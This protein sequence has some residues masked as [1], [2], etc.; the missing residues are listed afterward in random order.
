[1]IADTDSNIDPV[2]LIADMGRRARPAAP[3]SPA[4][5]PA[6]KAAHSRRRAAIRDA[7]PD[8]LPPTRA[9]WP[10]RRRGLVRRDARPAAARR[11]A[12]RR[13]G[14][15]GRGGRRAA[16]SGRADHRPTRAPQ[17][18]GA[19]AASAC[20]SASI[21]IIY[22]SRPNVTADAAR[23][24]ADGGQCRDPA[25]R[26]GGARRATARS[27]PR[28]R[29]ASPP[30]ACP[31]MR[32]N[33]CRPPIAPRSARCCARDGLDRHH[34]A[35][36]RQEPCRARAGRGAG[37]GARASRRHQPHLCPRLGRSGDGARRS[38]SMPRCAAPASAAR[39]RR[40]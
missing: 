25:R 30:P 32:C 29:R 8:I 10:A 11:G 28:W 14:R 36:R 6:P 37:A 26:L 34:R 31:P 20:R 12:D 27:M 15:G 2:K 7:A 17:W 19:A 22:E 5:R 23:A 3:R 38:S 24:G 35:A 33:S 39:P 4:C 40:C 16:R 9:T 21:G 13:D 18:P 1:M